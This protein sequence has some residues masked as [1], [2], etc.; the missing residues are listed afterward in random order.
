MGDNMFNNF[1]EEARNIIVSAKIERKKLKHP[2]VGSEHL[3]LAILKDNNS[4]SKKLKEYDVNYD[5]FKEELINI[6]G[7]GK[8]E[9][10]L[11]LYTPLL[12]RILE[13][14]VIDSKE[15]NSDVTIEHIFSAFL[16]EGEGVAI[17]ILLGMNI[18]VEELYT[19]FMYKI[20]PTKKDGGKLLLDE[21]GVDLTKKAKKGELDP[22]IGRE[23][24]LKRI[25]EILSRRTKNNPLLIGEAGVGKTAIIEE[26]S[27]KIA[28]D[29]VP[30]SLREKRIINVDMAS[31]VAGTKY[32]GEFEER[33]KKLLKEVEENDDIILFIDEI[34]TL[35]GAGGAEGAIDASNIFKPALARNKFRCIGATTVKEYK[36]FIEKD[37]A[38]ER[39]FQKVIVEIPNIEDTKKIL[40]QIKNIYEK[41]HYVKL[42]DEILDFI[43]ESSE[44]YIHD[45]NQPDKALDILDEVCAS[46]NVKED[47]ILKKYNSLKKEYDLILEK[48]EQAIVNN[49]FELASDLKDKENQ[50][51]ND[52]NLLEI[53]LFKKKPKKVT[54]EDVA[55]ILSER[56]NVP[57]HELLKN[58]KKIIKDIEK[59]M[60]N[61]IYGQDNALRQAI[62]IAKMRKLGYQ[63]DK[64][65]SMLFAGPSGVGKTLLAK[66]FGSCITDHVI[67]LDMSEYS[68]PHSVSKIIGAPPGYVG[69]DSFSNVL[70]EVKNYPYSVIILDEVERAHPN[71]LNLFLNIL[72]EGKIKDSSGNNI[73]FNHT[74]I[75][76]TSNIGFDDISVGFCKQKENEIKEKL[77]DYFSIPFLNRIDSTIIF[78]KFNEETITKLIQNKIKNVINK[79]PN[80]K[81]QISPTINEEIKE[82]SE[83]LEYGAR[84]IDKIINDELVDII[85]EHMINSEENINI[86]TLNKEITI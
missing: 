57:Q 2:Y 13:T 85:F 62:K 56:T 43:V 21:I 37:S 19:D 18:D 35:V 12:K 51:M 3:L 61:I 10:D 65:Y 72:E 75:I 70:E 8:E 31:L 17:R 53:N 9:S 29:E 80:Y 50:I 4:I 81:I 67:K 40:K 66:T 15:N 58:N 69:F 64:C 44:K 47:R 54:K 26:L 32:R 34:H 6:V 28:N 41:Y 20:I 60:N 52:I 39:R 1:T 30:Y 77:K 79:Y 59:K 76:M 78:N 84:R 25:I 23:K 22:V 24:E 83:Y 74:V 42:D 82:K 27:R 45:R 7:I 38:L 14:A 46:V 55:K 63:N 71:V 33:V 68:E 16:E 5:N 73:Y 49:N 48:K 36:T 86:K 11:F